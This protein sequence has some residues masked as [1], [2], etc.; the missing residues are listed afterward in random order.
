MDGME[1]FFEESASGLVPR[2]SGEVFLS[3]L[4]AGEQLT[5]GGTSGT[6]DA[7]EEL[8]SSLPMGRA[9]GGMDCEA[10]EGAGTGGCALYNL[11]D[12]GV[13]DSCETGGANTVPDAMGQDADE[14]GVGVSNAKKSSWTR[15]V[16][17][18]KVTDER[19][20]SPSRMPALEASMHLSIK[21]LKMLTIHRLELV[22][23]PSK[24][25]TSFTIFI[26]GRLVLGCA[27]QKAV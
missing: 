14:D 2:V 17:V 4:V 6:E 5:E 26:H 10:G 3:G 24:R 9:G 27:M 23:I 18:R 25:T 15:R 12:E 13:G 7:E 11:G 21:S 8:I 19:E 1:F 16:R 20:P 22:L